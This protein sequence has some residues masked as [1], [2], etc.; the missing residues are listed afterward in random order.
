[1][2]ILI[3]DD[4]EEARVLLDTLLAPLGETVLEENGEAALITYRDALDQGVPFDLVC[5]D[6][7][8]P[9]RD[10]QRVLG[11]MRRM[12]RGRGIAREGASRILMTTGVTDRH[13]VLHALE[14]GADGY[15]VKPIHRDA[16][17]ARLRDLGL[18]LGS[19]DT[20][21]A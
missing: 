9:G 12:D 15:L 16:L 21:G 6:I 13:H 2:R 10:G 18:D 3:V 19:P 17:L 20:P 8:M 1:V 14:N 11:T 7:R 4:D 5:L